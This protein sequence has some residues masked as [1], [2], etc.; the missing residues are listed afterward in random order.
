MSN[1]QKIDELEPLLQSIFHAHSNKEKLQILSR[2][3]SVDEFLRNQTD[4]LFLTDLNPKYDFVIRSIIAIGQA[5]I[6]F[7]PKSL[8]DYYSEKLQTLIDSLVEI[9]LFY[10]PIGG[11]IGYYL[12]ILKLMV[13]KENRSDIAYKRPTGTDISKFEGEIRRYVKQG[14]KSLPQMAEIYPVGG[15]GDRLDLK[16]KETGEPLPA[17]KL[18]FGGI[19]L[20]EGLIQDLQA[21]EYLFYK[22]FQ[23]QVITPI[24]MMTSHEKDNHRHIIE[25]CEQRHW[26]GRPKDHFFLFVQPLAPVITKEG[27]WSLTEPLT[28]ALKPGGHGVI[29]KLAAD[30]G[31]LSELLLKKRTKAL[32]RQINN[33]ISGIDYGL[34]AFTGIGLQEDKTFGFASCE[35]LLNASEGM[36]VLCEKKTKVDYEYSIT[37]I[38]YT[39]FAKKGIEDVSLDPKGEYSAF[40]AN[41]NILFVD[42]EKIKKVSKRVPFPGKY[43]NMK[44]K[45]LFISPTGEVKE[46]EGGRLE[47]TMQNIA[48][49]LIDC[50]PAPINED[51]QKNLQTYIT[52]NHR[53]K[54][55]SV[56]KQSHHPGKPLKETPEGC[57]YDLLVNYY[58]LLVNYCDFDLP[59]LPKKEEFLDK[60]PSFLVWIHPALGPLF[61]IMSQKIHYGQIKSGSELFLSIAELQLSHLSLDGSLRVIAHCIMGKENRDEVLIYSEKTGKCILKNVSVEN[62]GVDEKAP[63]IFWKQEI[64]RHESC[65][66]ILHGNAEFY[67]ENVCFKGSHHIEVPDGHRIIA[68]NDGDTVL[69]KQEPISVPSWHWSYTFDNQ[70]NI[71]LNIT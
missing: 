67:A 60:K 35:R 1:Q 52:Y 45:T 10:E 39:E 6:V 25:I 33:P 31:V 2:H 58:D 15:A 61:T 38:E 53:H 54:T 29:W 5:P 20:L 69:F 23:Q 27:D 70:D 30:Q 48:D 24:A 11:I 63:N 22:L 17:A 42:I 66:I 64:H 62:K 8:P 4:Y 43:L 47:T 28:I 59:N 68:Y 71:K 51:Q 40:P 12:T 19:T 65:T 32:V 55:I 37:N 3:P 13:E 16:D 21:R 56:T 57:F 14:I 34:L 50:F 26:F 44:T 41:T 18:L 9:D 36:D 46:S 7:N 49:E